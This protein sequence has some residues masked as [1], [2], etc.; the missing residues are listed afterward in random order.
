LLKNRFSCRLT[1]CVAL[2]GLLPTVATA[3]APLESPSATALAAD[4]AVAAPSA[5][6]KIVHLAAHALVCAQ[7]AGVANGARTLS[8]IDY[9]LPSTEQRLWVFDLEHRSVLFH[10]L[11]AHGRNT[12]DN[13]AAHFS[14]A[15]GSLMSSIG[16]FITAD[17][18]V[19][20][21]GYSLRL[22]GLEPG[23]N[24]NALDRDIV[25]HGAA[26]VSPDLIHS[27]GRLGRSFGCPAVRPSI[28]RQLID[29]IRDGSFVFAYYPD[30]DWL[31]TSNFLGDCSGTTVAA[32][33]TNVPVPTL[34]PAAQTAGNQSR[35]ESR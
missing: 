5:D 34:S 4:L 31:K 19:G 3:V 15:P 20:H 24:D 9:S 2:V 18:Y 28:A 25:M 6:P 7:V 26:Y 22:R 33:A 13:Q 30:R 16:S 14:N 10:E 27:Q 29:A 21:N 32:V 23:I 8:L 35:K 1:L 11:V 17:T 12:G